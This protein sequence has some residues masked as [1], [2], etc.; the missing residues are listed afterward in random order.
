MTIRVPA[1]MRMAC[2]RRVGSRSATRTGTRKS[3]RVSPRSA[4]VERSSRGIAI[5]IETPEGGYPNGG[6]LRAES[7]IHHP[8]RG[9]RAGVGPYSYPTA[10]TIET[11]LA[12]RAG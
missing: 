6:G 8:R 11:L 2:R 5:V 1:L 9:R 4:A 10:R 7:S 3:A 12:R